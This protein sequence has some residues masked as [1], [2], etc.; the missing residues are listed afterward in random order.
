MNFEK[1][2]DYVIELKNYQEGMYEYRTLTSEV[3]ITKAIEKGKKIV[4]LKKKLGAKIFLILGGIFLVLGLILALI[5]S[6]NILIFSTFFGI[7][8]GIGI[9]FIVLGLFKMRTSFLVL[10]PEGLV[11]KLQGESIK[12]FK[13]EEISLDLGASSWDDISI[14]ILMPNEDFIKFNYRDYCSEEYSESQSFE[15]IG[16]DM[17]TFQFYYRIGKFNLQDMNPEEKLQVKKDNSSTESKNMVNYSLEDLR[18]EYHKYKEKKYKFGKYGTREQIKN[19]FLKG[20]IFVLKGGLGVG[21]WIL[22]ILMFA[23]TLLSLFMSLDPD[24]GIFIILVFL[25]FPLGLFPLLTLRGFLVIGPLGVYYQKILSSGVFSWK[26]VNNIKHFT[27]TYSGFTTGVV[28]KIYIYHGRKIRFGSSNYLNKEF[29]RKVGREMFV[30]LF[31]IYSQL[32]KNHFPNY[33]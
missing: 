14:N 3:D 27:Q 11:Y 19:E 5:L 32:G 28:V 8:G 17:L 13:W 29:P 31:Y 25:T 26:N 7:F 23:I 1:L 4:F 12:G 6:V 30:T 9:V 10:G 33:N 20:K 18:K 15:V 16:L 2:N 22:T 24:T 21:G